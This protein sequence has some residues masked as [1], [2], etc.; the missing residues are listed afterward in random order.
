MNP[1]VT[2]EKYFYFLKNN[3]LT[4][5]CV[6]LMRIFKDILISIFPPYI[7]VNS[8]KC[9]LGCN[10]KKRIIFENH[11]LMVVHFLIRL[12]FDQKNYLFS[13]NRTSCAVNKKQSIIFPFWDKFVAV[14]SGSAII[15]FIFTIWDKISFIPEYAQKPSRFAQSKSAARES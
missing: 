12:S 13:L 14:V 8:F 10:K 11:W 3:W 1:N 9:F 6:L 5:K 2:Q 4:G 15:F 7:P